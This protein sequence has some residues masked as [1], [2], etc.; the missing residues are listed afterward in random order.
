MLLM[1]QTLRHRGTEAIFQVETVRLASPRLLPIN[2]AI[3]FHLFFDKFALTND[4]SLFLS[5]SFVETEHV[6]LF[7]QVFNGSRC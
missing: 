3:P 7:T 1:E 2:F 4:L 6:L 5:L